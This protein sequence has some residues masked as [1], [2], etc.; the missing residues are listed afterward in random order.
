MCPIPCYYGSRKEVNKMAN[1]ID[2]VRAGNTKGKEVTEMANRMDRANAENTE[3]K[4]VNK[5]ANRI[6]GLKTGNTKIKT[7][8]VKMN[9]KKGLLMVGLAAVLVFGLIPLGAGVAMAEEGS[10]TDSTDSINNGEMPDKLAE[11]LDVEVISASYALIVLGKTGTAMMMDSRLADDL[12]RQKVIEYDEAMDVFMAG[13]AMVMAMR[14]GLDEFNKFL[15]SIGMQGLP[16]GG[17]TG[18]RFGQGNG[19]VVS[20]GFG[21]MKPTLVQQ[22][23]DKMG[24][25]WEGHSYESFMSSFADSIN[26]SQ[27]EEC[28]DCGQGDISEEDA[29]TITLPAV[30]ITLHEDGTSIWTTT[31]TSDTGAITITHDFSDGRMAQETYTEDG[32]VYWYWRDSDGNSGGRWIVDPYEYPRPDGEGGLGPPV[33]VIIPCPDFRDEEGEAKV[34]VRLGHG[35]WEIVIYEP[36][37]GPGGI[38]Q[39]VIVNGA[40]DPPPPDF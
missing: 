17:M 11:A 24:I 19:Y 20:P 12:A 2:L 10:K 4:E 40:V 21:E 15:E 36:G 26:E 39:V 16:E 13:Q 37:Q 7:K 1:I 9:L 22:M 3:I 29:E 28:R 30:T 27:F 14:G 5:M 38:H 6:D 8:E 35:L 18:L 25:D 23:M 33:A 32:G 34:L 31:D